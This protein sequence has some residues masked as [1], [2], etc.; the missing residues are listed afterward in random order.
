M[1][2]DGQIAYEAYCESVAWV[3]FS[4]TKLPDWDKQSEKLQKA[5]CKAALAINM[6]HAT[7]FAELDMLRKENAHLRERLDAEAKLSDS[8]R[9]NL[10][11]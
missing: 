2:H 9:R 8:Y 6:N 5:W 7:E 10:T 3:S 4:G 11:K 1:K